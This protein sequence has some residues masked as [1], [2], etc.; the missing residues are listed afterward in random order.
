MDGELR[1]AMG[2]YCCLRRSIAVSLLRIG[3]VVIVARAVVLVGGV[4]GREAVASSL[5]KVGWVLLDVIY[6]T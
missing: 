5:G 1:T 4:F 2:T 6:P 3:C